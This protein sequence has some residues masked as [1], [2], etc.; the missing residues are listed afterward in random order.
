MTTEYALAVK[1]LEHVRQALDPEPLSSVIAPGAEVSW[2]V[3]DPGMVYV[4]FVR[5]AANSV[6][7]CGIDYMR[8]TLA[9]GVLR[10][11]NTMQEDG[12]A[13]PDSVLTGY[14]EQMLQDAVDSRDAILEAIDRCHRVS[15]IS[16]LP[17]G[18][19]GGVA[20]G[21]WTFEVRYPP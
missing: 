3:C 18:P 13:P 16:W 20:G 6:V 11:V 15:S 5:M 19:Q 21:E 8:T 10:C 14:S 17:Q 1:I 9:V 7:N 4:R 12:S 2:D